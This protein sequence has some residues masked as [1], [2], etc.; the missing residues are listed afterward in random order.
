MTVQE[1][2][3]SAKA[4]NTWGTA[5]TSVDVDFVTNDGRLDQTQLDLM[6]DA[7]AE[8]LESLWKSLVKELNTGIDRITALYAYG[9]IVT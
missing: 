1:A 7:P 5:P 8:E 9:H 2:V 4:H 6:S 3:R